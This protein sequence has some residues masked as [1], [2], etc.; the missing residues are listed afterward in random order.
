MLSCLFIKKK[1]RNPSQWIRSSPLFS[2]L[3]AACVIQSAHLS[4]FLR[5][6]LKLW[7]Y[8]VVIS[9]D[10][11]IRARQ[12]FRSEREC[13]RVRQG[14]FHT[15]DRYGTALTAVETHP[16]RATVFKKNLQRNPNHNYSA[17]HVKSFSCWNLFFPSMHHRLGKKQKKKSLQTAAIFFFSPSV[18]QTGKKNRNTDWRLQLLRGELCP[19]A[20]C[21]SSAASAI[22]T[23]K[24]SHLLHATT[25]K[26]LVSS[27]IPSTHK[28]FCLFMPLKCAA[29]QRDHKPKTGSHL[30]SICF[31]I[32]AH[33]Y[34]QQRKSTST[35]TYDATLPSI[36]LRWLRLFVILFSEVRERLFPLA[37]MTRLDR[38]SLHLIYTGCH[39]ARLLHFNVMC[40][41]VIWRGYLTHFLTHFQIS[42]LHALSAPAIGFLRLLFCLFRLETEQLQ[43]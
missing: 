9:K 20:A 40:L 4:P 39:G 1:K 17:C 41:N 8:V 13:V 14:A 28:Q 35:S 21:R 30:K 33:N 5:R 27:S 22:P 37:F 43:V 2:P 31:S 36:C 12:L 15:C 3:T 6:P 38:T 7:W 26:M 16:Y 24:C 34:R 23:W 25:R 29:V 42:G 10:C 19:H 18:W 32:T 11:D